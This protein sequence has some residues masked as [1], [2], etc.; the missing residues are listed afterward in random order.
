MSCSPRSDQEHFPNSYQL[1]QLIRGHSVPM[2]EE[3]LIFGINYPIFVLALPVE[4]CRTPMT[5]WPFRPTLFF[6]R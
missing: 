2:P 5:R 3:I 6:R 1:Y 4:N